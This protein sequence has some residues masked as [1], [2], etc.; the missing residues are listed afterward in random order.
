MVKD[1]KINGLV[2]I[3]FF[4]G[5]IFLLLILSGTSLIFL[6]LLPILLSILALSKGLGKFF[7]S[8]SLTFSL[9]LLYRSLEDLLG[10]LILITLLSLSFIFLIRFIKNDKV[11]ISLAF[12]VTSLILIGF[13]RISL[14]RL[15]LSLDDLARELRLVVEEAVSYDLDFSYYKLSIGLYPTVFSLISFAYSLLAIKLIRNYLSIAYGIGED[16]LKVNNMRIEKKDLLIISLGLFLAYFLARISGA[17]TYVEINILGI[18]LV[19]LFFNGLSVFDYMI[20]K[21]NL[22]LSRGIQWFFILVLI[23]ILA[24]FFLILG[25]ADIILDIRSERRFE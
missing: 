10:P 6:A 1:I 2:D 12:L 15:G 14:Y 8:L 21:L 13:Y 16:L 19:V 7:L 11:Q 24:I 22:P 17:R 23:Q 5:I 25:F 4:V 20:S 9:G 3:I 18:M